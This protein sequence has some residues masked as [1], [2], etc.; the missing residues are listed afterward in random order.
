MTG[1]AGSDTFKWS[2]ADVPASG[3]ARD[4]VTDFTL[5]TPTVQGDVLDIKD[6][7]TGS[8]RTAE[9][10]AAQLDFAASGS[11]TVISVHAVGS[12]DAHQTI[13]LNNVSLASLAGTAGAGEPSDIA[14]LQKLLDGHNIKV[15]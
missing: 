11:N 5:S 15:S 9:G 1:G 7:L 12:T 6:L 14:A 2:L 10:L 3:V 13:T 4:V 8:D